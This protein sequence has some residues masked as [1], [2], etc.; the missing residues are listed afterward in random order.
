MKRRSSC[1]KA[2]YLFIVSIIELGNKIAVGVVPGPGDRLCSAK[3]MIVCRIIV[4]LRYLSVSC[5][6]MARNKDVWTERVGRGCIY[7]RSSGGILARTFIYF[8]LRCC[9]IT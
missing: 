6:S 2:V 8:L 5:H 1:S 4:P 3:V 9:G 7:C